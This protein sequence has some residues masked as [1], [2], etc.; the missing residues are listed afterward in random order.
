[1]YSHGTE[2]KIVTEGVFGDGNHETTQLVLDALYEANPR[3]KDVLDV[4]TGT[5]VQSI[6]AAKWGA[7]IVHAVDIDYQA[8]KTARAN[9]KRNNVYV[10]SEL[11]IFNEGIDYPYDITVANLPAPALRDYLSIAR[12]SMAPDGVL[13]FSWPRRFNLS[14]ECDLYRWEI[15]S[16]IEGIEYDAYTIRRKR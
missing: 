7:I 8:I 4:G 15:V 9:F 14:N 6:Y 13:I 3:D 5:G 11:N 12:E 10:E 1:M 16:R 2:V